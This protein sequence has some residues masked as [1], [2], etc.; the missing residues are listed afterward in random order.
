MHRKGERHANYS[1]G[2][3]QPCGRFGGG[4]I[5][6][7]RL[8]L[9]VDG[10]I[11]IFDTNVNR[12]IPPNT[13]HH[14]FFSMDFCVLLVY[15]RAHLSVYKLISPFSLHSIWLESTLSLASYIATNHSI[16]ITKVIVHTHT[17]G[18]AHAIKR[19]VMQWRKKSTEKKAATG[20]VMATLRWPE[21]TCRQ[22]RFSW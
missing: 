10:Y 18:G 9:H 22:N 6:S 20:A 7:H 1:C 2:R 3:L 16:N 19:H 14:P 11:N 5:R 13:H 21:L 15:G 17:F 4:W 12:S 8:A